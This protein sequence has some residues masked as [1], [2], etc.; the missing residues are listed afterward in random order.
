MSLFT[1][2]YLED[3]KVSQELIMLPDG[4]IDLDAD[5]ATRT[6][7]DEENKNNATVDILNAGGFQGDV[8]KKFATQNFARKGPITEPNTRA[9]QDDL[10]SIK[11]PDQH[12]Y[13]TNG[14]TVT[15]DAYFISAE[16]K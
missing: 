14:S 6:L 15:G 1:R 12:F 13:L 10:A 8:F 5:P 16:Q 2:K 11:H 4:S 3:S 7:I 9:R